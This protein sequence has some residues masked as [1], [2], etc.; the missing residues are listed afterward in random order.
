MQRQ[1]YRCEEMR[2]TIH[3]LLLLDCL[4]DRIRNRDRMN[5]WIVCRVEFRV[6]FGQK[7][8]RVQCWGRRNL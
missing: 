2:N 7:L 4:Y 1:T 3:T 6:M 5:E 8:R